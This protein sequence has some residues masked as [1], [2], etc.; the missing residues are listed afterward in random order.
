MRLGLVMGIGNDWRKSLENIK[1]AEQLGYEMVVTGEAWG[2]SAIP[3]LTAIALNTSTIQ[4]G[5]SIINCFSRSPAAIAQEFATMEVL[6]Q[7]RMIL[8]LGSSGEFVIE[9][10]HGIRYRKPLSRL[11]EYVEIFNLLIS[12]EQLHYSGNLFQMNRGF[13]LDFERL[14]DH[15]PVY[16][17]AINPKSIRQTG[18]IADGI[19][20]I[21]WPKERLPDLRKTLQ[22]AAID[23]GRLGDKIIIAPQTRVTILDG[24]N[25][26][27]KWM[28][29]RQPL[30]HYINRMGRFYWEM[31]ERNG[32]EAEVAAS[33]DAWAHRDLDGAL[34]AISRHMVRSTHVIGT[35]EEVRE[36]LHERAELGADIQILSGLD[37]AAEDVRPLLESLAT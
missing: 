29:A 17:A 19:Y 31:L 36:Q 8:G 20:P 37:G 10:F 35:L 14:R 34:N 3:W 1:V 23:T 33:R 2:P 12:G 13:Q 21:H 4:V 9:H 11:R 24:T 15:I 28:S 30:H 32:F 6:S 25:D 22:A 7:G 18:E 27:A 26:E 16:I 5:S